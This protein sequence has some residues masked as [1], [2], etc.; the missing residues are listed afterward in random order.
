MFSSKV[1]LPSWKD[2]LGFG[3]KLLYIDSF[4]LGLRDVID[5]Q[6]Y[7]SFIELQIMCGGNNGGDERRL[8]V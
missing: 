3:L 5:I 1:I 4:L 7:P 6:Q 2:P 8:D